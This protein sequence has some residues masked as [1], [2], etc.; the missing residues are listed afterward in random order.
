[1]PF[2][3]IVRPVRDPPTADGNLNRYILDCFVVKLLAMTPRG[4]LIRRERLPD[5][6]IH[7]HFQ[8]ISMCCPCP[9]YMTLRSRSIKRKN[10]KGS[11][12]WPLQPF[13]LLVRNGLLICV[14]KDR[15]VRQ[16]QAQQLLPAQGQ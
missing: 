12:E 11:D 13:D 6:L 4:Q 15:P 5:F 2:H 3:V 8:R 9:Y 1:M 7:G 16:D 10:E 14:C